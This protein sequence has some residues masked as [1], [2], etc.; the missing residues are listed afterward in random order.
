MCTHGW[1]S[2]GTVHCNS[3]S[4]VVLCTRSAAAVVLDRP[5][6]VPAA[7]ALQQPM[8]A[9]GAHEGRARGQWGVG[10][11]STAQ[12]QQPRRTSGPALHGRTCRTP[13]PTTP[14]ASPHLRHITGNKHSSS[15]RAPVLVPS[16]VLPQPWWSMPYS[17]RWRGWPSCRCAAKRRRAAHVYVVLCAQTHRARPIRQHH[18]QL[19][20]GSRYPQP[21]A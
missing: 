8:P 4:T 12:L 19:Q 3:R 10:F 14:T 2:S 6:A 15:R 18:G 7:A 17:G 20:H 9:A 13:H 1:P 16:A 21:H 11:G 5:V